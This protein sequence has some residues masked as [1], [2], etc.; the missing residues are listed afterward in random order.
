MHLT[1]ESVH[2]MCAVAQPQATETSEEPRHV[3]YNGLQKT[4]VSHLLLTHAYW[5]PVICSEA[6]LH[7]PYMQYSGHRLC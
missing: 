1:R 6:E 3:A 2:L 5:W 4:I 7:F